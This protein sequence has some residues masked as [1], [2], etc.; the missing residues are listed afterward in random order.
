MAKG[1]KPPTAKY[2]YGPYIFKF[3]AFF[4]ADRFWERAAMG[5][6]L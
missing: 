6:K 5:G 4:S 3:I 2:S 1:K